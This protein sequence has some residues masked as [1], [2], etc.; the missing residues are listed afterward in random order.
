M[1]HFSVLPLHHS[2]IVGPLGF[3][4]SPLLP[5]RDNP[6]PV[7]PKVF[8]VG[9]SSW[10]SSTGPYGYLACDGSRPKPS[11]VLKTHSNR[12]PLDS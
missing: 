7:G 1:E 8:V 11:L 5:I 2:P 9:T 12:S 6:F 4:P 3:E 10:L